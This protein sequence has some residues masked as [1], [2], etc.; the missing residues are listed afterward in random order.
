[1]SHPKP[2][3]RIRVFIDIRGVYRIFSMRVSS[4]AS[5]IVWRTQF[6]K[7][8]YI[9]ACVAQKMRSKS[10][11]RNRR[12]GDISPHPCVRPCLSPW[13]CF[14]FKGCFVLDSPCTIFRETRES[15]YYDNMIRSNF[16]ILDVQLPYKPAWPCPG[17]LVGRY[18][19][20][21]QEK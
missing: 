20:N 19:I 7:K 10:G 21:R 18:V 8:C 15:A 12:K 1:M 2:V 17:W 3:P 13:L 4:R 5:K 14:Y 16:Y 9:P 6:K 11:S